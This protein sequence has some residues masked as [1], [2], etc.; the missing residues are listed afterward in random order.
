MSPPADPPSGSLPATFGGFLPL[1]ARFYGGP[2]KINRWK[3]SP[4]VRLF[5]TL[6]TIA[7]LTAPLS[8]CASE[9]PATAAA[10][11]VAVEPLP[12]GTSRPASA[13]TV[14]ATV[15]DYRQPV[16]TVGKP[17]QSGYEYAAAD[18]KVCVTDRATDPIVLGQNPWSLAYADS[19]RAVASS[20]RYDDFPLPAYPVGYDGEPQT[21]AGQCKRGWL[22]FPAPAGQ[23]PVT[24][25][26]Q[27]S[28]EPAPLPWTVPDFD[29]DR[30]ACAALNG[31]DELQRLEPEVTRP[32]AEGALRATDPAL[33][34]A[35][36]TLLRATTAV[37]EADN[38]AGPLNTAL[39]GAWLDVSGACIDRYGDGPW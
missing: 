38:P 33:V 21:P 8:G 16:T 12:F 24:I 34:E 18:L 3:V 20:E 14:E 19:T 13:G 10:T 5:R 28:D 37:E 30:A 23:R 2:T 39:F 27:P 4:S 29:P 17:A 26:Y 35:G 31:I 1:T 36:Q 25:D 6:V 22:V 11:P 15:Y 7:A 9:P 32:V